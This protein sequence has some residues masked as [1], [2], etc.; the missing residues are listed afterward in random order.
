MTSMIKTFPST[1]TIKGK[2]IC[3]NEKALP[4]R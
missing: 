2:A 4:F 1:K 3:I